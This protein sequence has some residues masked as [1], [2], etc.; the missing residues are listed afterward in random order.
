M[1]LKQIINQ[2]TG[3]KYNHNPNGK[4]Q[5]ADIL[6]PQGNVFKDVYVIDFRSFYPSIIVSYNLL[7]KEMS[8]WLIEMFKK[9]QQGDKQAKLM[10]SMIYGQLKHFDINIANRITQIGREWIR[11]LRSYFEQQ[12][13]KIIY[14]HTD[15]VMI[16]DVQDEGEVIDLKNSFIDELSS[17][18]AFP[19]PILKL[20]IENKFKYIYF[21]Q[22]LDGSFNKTS[23]I[24]IK[25]DDTWVMKGTMKPSLEEIEYI[26][27]VK[28]I[29]NQGKYIV[30]SKDLQEY[31]DKYKPNHNINDKFINTEK[32]NILQVNKNVIDL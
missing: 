20:S 11:A 14:S 30:T 26:N 22:N 10:M 19:N 5:G 21:K 16:A 17:R 15:C 4:L 31:I 8:N 29:L 23:Y 1:D 25:Y 27:F 7:G 12:G 13:Y 24:G 6:E 2:K 9:K 32:L 3:L 18:F 28:H